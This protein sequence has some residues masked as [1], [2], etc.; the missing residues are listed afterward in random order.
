MVF[1]ALLFVLVVLGLVGCGG[2]VEVPAPCGGAG[3]VGGDGGGAGGAGGSDGGAGGSAG[4]GG[5]SAG[6]G[7]VGGASGCAPLVCPVADVCPDPDFC[8][9]GEGASVAATCEPGAI[10]QGCGAVAFDW[11]T[12][13]SEEPSGPH[14]VVC[15]CGGA[16]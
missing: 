9:A 5:A 2:G 3:G 16:S 14:V 1:Q 7:G 8:G 12:C 15:C 10:D 13:G 6:A 4:E 11:S